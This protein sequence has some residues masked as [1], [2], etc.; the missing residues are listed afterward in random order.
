[1]AIFVTHQTIVDD[2]GAVIEPVAWR[3]ATENDKDIGCLAL[4]MAFGREMD[5]ERARAALEK[6]GL[7]CESTLKQA[8]PTA[9]YRIMLDSLAW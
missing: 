6:A 2:D 3:V 9:V 4:S 7:V 5:A 8:G 1:M